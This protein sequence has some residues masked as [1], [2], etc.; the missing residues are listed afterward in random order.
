MLQHLLYVVTPFFPFPFSKYP[1]FKAQ[2][3]PTEIF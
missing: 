1:F 3:M 2:G